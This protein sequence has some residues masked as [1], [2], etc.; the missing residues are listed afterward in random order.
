MIGLD[1]HTSRMKT[2]GLV[3]LMLALS[4][5]AQA[6]KRPPI[7][8]V[9]DIEAASV[10]PETLKSLA[11]RINTRVAASG[12]Y[13]IVPP[14]EIRRALRKEKIDS[15]KECYDDACQIEL[16]KELAAEQIISTRISS[17]AGACQVSMNLYDL[18]ASVSVGAGL[19]DASCEDAGLRAGV[20][21]ALDQLLG[22]ARPPPQPPAPVLTTEAGPFTPD[23]GQILRVRDYGGARPRGDY[24][25]E[26]EIHSSSPCPSGWRN[27][28]TYCEQK[29]G[30]ATFTVTGW[31]IYE[32]KE[33]ASRFTVRASNG[34][35]D[36]VEPYCTKI[37]VQTFTRA[38]CSASGAPWQPSGN[39]NVEPNTT[40]PAHKQFP[41]HATDRCIL[42]ARFAHGGAYPDVRIHDV[43]RQ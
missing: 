17:I 8:A 27:T 24:L 3:V 41:L 12:R 36:C 9:F 33:P 13:Q 7:V 14:S 15:Y 37:N 10:N 2:V 18:R 19:S 6:K 11:A 34:L 43:S 21:E 40:Y 5:T 28:A 22:V 16:G 31:A 32:L 38:S 29:M 39:F 35:D 42:V 23:P 4:S 25:L 30:G 20:D 26:G 1:Y